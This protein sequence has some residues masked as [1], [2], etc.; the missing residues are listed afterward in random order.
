MHISVCVCTY[1]RPVWLRELL[2]D[3][4]KQQSKDQFT[5]EVIVVDNDAACSAREVVAEA[6]ATLPMKITYCEEPRRSISFA[7]NKTI[8]HASGDFIA[9]IDDDEFPESDWLFKLFEACTTRSVAGVLG[10]VR[11]RFES[12]TPTWVKKGGFYDRPEHETGFVMPW[13]ECRTGNVLFDRKIIAGLDP[14]FSPEFG[15]GGSDVDF[16]RRMTA[17]GHKFIWCNE[18]IVHEIVPPNRWKRSVLIRRALLRGRNSFRH[19]KGR[20]VRLVKAAL[21]IPFYALALPIL[22]LAGHHLFMRYLIKLCDHTGRLLASVGITP[23]RE[24]AM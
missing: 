23:I 5:F 1:Q 24:R 7:R 18:A 2:R 11:P 16:F 6:G 12:G 3:L 8:A 10:P 19:P 22:F 20:W 17:A 14:V 21:A 13:T 15:T 4:G 9:F